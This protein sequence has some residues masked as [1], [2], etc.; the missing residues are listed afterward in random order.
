MK[1]Y[2]VENGSIKGSDC[3]YKEFSMSYDATRNLDEAHLI[4]ESW[5]KF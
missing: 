5:L 1:N 2:L 4:A 3:P